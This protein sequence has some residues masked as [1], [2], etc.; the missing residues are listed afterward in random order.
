MLESV[1]LRNFQAHKDLT[2][3]FGPQLTTLIGITEAGK[4]TILRA[5][6]WVCLNE[7][8]GPAGSFVRWGKKSVSVT[9]VI[10]GRGLTRSKSDKGNVYI[11]DGKTFKAV[12]EKVP[13]EVAGFLKLADVNF[14][15]QLDPHFWFSDRPAD[16]S[17]SLNRIVNL[18]KIDTA[19]AAASTRVR[20]AK[21]EAEVSQTRLSDARKKRNGLRW[22]DVANGDLAALE[23]R[24]KSIRKKREQHD[25]L[26]ILLA[27]IA[28]TA[29]TRTLAETF[30]ETGSSLVLRGSHVL[31]LSERIKQLR[32]LIN[33]LSEA[34]ELS[35]RVV[36][37]LPDNELSRARA[38]SEKFDELSRVVAQ[39][40]HAERRTWQAKEIVT[41]TVATMFEEFGS[42]CPTCGQKTS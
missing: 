27:K 29:A 40:E 31:Q 11:L 37:V 41:R 32:T 35:Q 16:V 12:G 13:D 14:Q 42:V 24:E 10:D 3:T 9:L 18:E 8:D 17:R 19:L 39:L 15:G 20:R 21:L 30:T 36:P 6:R 1:A 26:A 33:G 23:Q 28:E 38:A 7:F 22:A 2:L 25:D 4:S 34:R 5:L